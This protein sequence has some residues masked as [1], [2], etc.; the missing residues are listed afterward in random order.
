MSDLRR[1]YNS[2]VHKAERMKRPLD[3]MP[4]SLGALSHS[5]VRVTL[6]DGSQWLVHKGD[7]FGKSS[8]TVVVDTRHMSDKW[9]VS[10]CSRTGS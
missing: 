1:L 9:R 4:F 6:A 5:G 7:N 10:I 2:G 3:G 8:Q